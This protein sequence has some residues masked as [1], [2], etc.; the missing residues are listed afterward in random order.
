MYDIL[1]KNGTI[2]DGTGGPAFRGD[3]A[4]HEE[5]IVAIGD[6]PR[7]EA[8]R[9]FDAAGLVIAPGFIDVN[10]HSDVYWQLFQSPYLE[11]MI[12]QGVTTIIGGNAG[13]S[14]AP[15]TEK[16]IIRS[17]QKWTD[18]DHINF[19]WLSVKEYLAELDR[20]KLGA[21]FATLIGHG[22]MRRGIMRDQSRSITPVEI[23]QMLRILDRGLS[24][25][26][27]GM[28]SGLKYTHAAGATVRELSALAKVVA[29]HEGVYATYIRNEEEGLLTAV[30]E[31]LQV[32][33]DAGVR[34]HITHLKA[35]NKENWPL[36]DEA[37]RKIDG[38][39]M[40]GQEVTFDIYPYTSASSV[41]YTFLPEW[42][43][44]QGRVAMM[45]QLRDA[46]I[47]RA[48]IQ[49]MEKSGYR[50]EDLII[51]VSQ[52]STVMTHRQ[53]GKIAE[54][55]G[56]SPEQAVISVLLASEGRTIVS[57][58]ALSPANIEHALENSQSIVSSNGAGYAFDHGKTGE[59]VHPRSFGT[60][61]RVLAE[62]VRKKKLISLEAAI[63]KMTGKPAAVFGIKKRGV[64]K[65]GN[66]AD[67][68][69]FDPERVR[70]R[71]TLEDP[72]Q[73]PEG[74]NAVI[75]NGQVAFDQNHLTKTL[76]GEIL[77]PPKKW[78]W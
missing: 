67:I 55:Q 18:V 46:A 33:R 58:E 44:R 48:V 14:L 19:N 31:A 6:F 77:R 34:V 25:G 45:A 49:D 32:G 16:R 10:N 41:L 4:I 15:L 5:R 42:V 57:H 40:A 27:I 56:I 61:P 39:V 62:Y 36:F 21:N 76:A 2:I 47:Q 75:V 74:I 69:I 38:A 28:S 17:I 64:L 29:K 22:T 63:H 26:A 73:L 11:G 50:Y 7:A 54:S 60:F 70:D 66:F 9:V 24:E 13:S 1:I 3:L 20:R 51:A 65:T 37:L 8:R 23:N 35:V 30:D 59:L 68:V 12:C 72:Y 78:F 52:M 43:T 71:A 53:I